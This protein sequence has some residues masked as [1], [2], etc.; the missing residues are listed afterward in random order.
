MGSTNPRRDYNTHRHTHT[1]WDHSH[2]LLQRPPLPGPSLLGRAPQLPPPCRLQMGAQHQP[3]PA[4]QPWEAKQALCSLRGGGNWRERRGRSDPKSPQ[5]GA[6]SPIP[7]ARGL[8]AGAGRPWRRH[9]R[10][11]C[12]WLQPHR[13]THPPKKG[14]E[15]Q[16][17]PL[18]DRL[19]G[20]HRLQLRTSV[21]Y[22]GGRGALV[23]LGLPGHCPGQGDTASCPAPR[24]ASR[25][26]L[27]LFFP[28]KNTHTKKKSPSSQ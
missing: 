9:R 2:L 14:I 5:Q 17:N 13:H 10:P 4:P 26:V 1:I 28:Q 23:P 8:R 11:R 20:R 7:A 3:G 15:E 22:T 19:R 18:R 21:C 12:T 16:G 6:P 27:L 24:H 25:I